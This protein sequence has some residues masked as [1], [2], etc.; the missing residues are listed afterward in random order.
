M[1]LRHLSLGLVLLAAQFAFSTLDSC[2]SLFEYMLLNLLS[3]IY[4]VVTPLFKHLLLN[5]LS[6]IYTVV[7]PL[8][9]HLLLSKLY[10][11]AAS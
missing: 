8:F 7:T 6:H 2:D 5:L 1:P 10:L 3:H 9:E 11:L 4:T